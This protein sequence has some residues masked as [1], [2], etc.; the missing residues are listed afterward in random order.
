MQADRQYSWV[1]DEFSCDTILTSFFV[2]FDLVNGIINFPK[3]GSW[4][5][6]VLCYTVAV[7]SSL[8]FRTYVLYAIQVLIEVLLPPFSHFTS[9]KH[10]AP[11]I[12]PAELVSRHET[13]AGSVQP[14]AE[15]PCFLGMA[16]Q[17]HSLR[18]PF[19]QTA[20]YFSPVRG[21]S[22][23]SASLCI[24][25]RSVGFLAAEQKR[26]ALLLHFALLVEPFIPSTPC[27]VPDGDLNFIADGCF[28]CTPVVL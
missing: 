19:Y 28:C 14:L 4:I 21:G 11:I 9:I 23:A 3:R 12:I 2:V 1:L 7:V 22:D 26:W 15:L 24:V 17:F 18:N 8:V 25:A 10:E 6:S 5:V 16:Q 20:V 27:H 13:V